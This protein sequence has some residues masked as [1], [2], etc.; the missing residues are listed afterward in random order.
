MPD[1]YKWRLEVP[2]AAPSV[3]CFKYLSLEAAEED[4]RDYAK[5][6]PGI[7][8]TII[9][10]KP[11]ATLTASMDVSYTFHKETH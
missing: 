10:E 4:A 7:P 9:E 1:L 11:F 3:Y 5:S 8:V 2:E 6:N